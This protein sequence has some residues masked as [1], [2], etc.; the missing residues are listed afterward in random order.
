MHFFYLIPSDSLPLSLVRSVEGS[1]SHALSPDHAS[2]PVPP[3]FHRRVVVTDYQGTKRGLMRGSRQWCSFFMPY[4]LFVKSREV[5]DAFCRDRPKYSDTTKSLSFSRNV[6]KSV[7]AS[8]RTAHGRLFLITM[9]A[10]KNVNI[11]AQVSMS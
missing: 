1:N 11:G 10:T 6:E 9:F 7:G 4:L 5:E 2:T 8:A 3:A